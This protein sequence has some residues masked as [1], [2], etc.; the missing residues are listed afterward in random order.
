M[1][2]S[3]RLVQFAATILFHSLQKGLS[4]DHLC[5][6]E[7]QSLS[8][9]SLLRQAVGY[10]VEACALSRDKAELLSIHQDRR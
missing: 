8:R 5:L 10:R 2:E 1:S 3:P 6:Q 9:H 7:L 4:H